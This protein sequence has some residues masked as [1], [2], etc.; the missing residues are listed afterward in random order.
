LKLRREDLRGITSDRK[1]D[2]RNPFLRELRMSLGQ[3]IDG[4]DQPLS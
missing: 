3:T 4:A 2:Q 1:K